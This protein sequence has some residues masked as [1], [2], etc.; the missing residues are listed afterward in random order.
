MMTKPQPS[1]PAPDSARKPVAAPAPAK[2]PRKK[3]QDRLPPL[4]WAATHGP[5]SGA[6]SATTGAAAVAL[7]G[8]AT[9]MPDAL[10]LLLGAAG[11]VGH[12][13][14]HSLFKHL[15][16]RT[17]VARCASWLLAGGWTTYAIT[18]G[19]LTWAC[20]GTLAGIGIGIGAMASNA[21][22]H[23]EVA[24]QDRLATTT[25]TAA[26]AAATESLDDKRR[27]VA[28]E[29]S[30]RIRRLT[31][32]DAPVTSVEFWKNG[33]G[34]S[35]GGHL[36]GGAIWT[37]IRDRARHMAADARLP[38]GCTIDVEEG[39]IQGTYVVDIT[40]VNIMS[41]IVDYPDDWTPLSILTGIPWGLRPSSDPVVV[42]LRE[43]C[44][45]ILGPPGSGKSTFL[46]GILAGFARCT[47][48][49]TWVIDLKGG[50]IG[51]PWAQPWLEAQGHAPAAHGVTQA[52]ADTQPGVDWIAHTP[53]EA[54]LML[55]AFLAIN[56]ARQ[57]G[58][59][60]LMNRANTTL[61]P[62]SAKIPQ[63]ELVIDEGAELLSAPNSDP[64]MKE[65]KRLVKKAMRTTRAMAERLVLTAIDGNLSAIGNTEVRKFSPVGV[66]LTSGENSTSNV[67]KLH[68]R[69][70]ID[71]NQLTEKGAG[72]IGQA[73]ADGFKPTAFKTWRTSPLMV[74]ACV[75]ATNRIRPT[76][77]QTSSTA[78]GLDY[79]N[80]WSAQRAGWLWG[81][82]DYRE[83]TIGEE[84]FGDDFTTP[85]ATA[86]TT[87]PVRRD[88]S[89]NLSYKRTP[90]PTPAHDDADEL[91][92]RLMREIDARYGTTEEPTT[93]SQGLNLSYKRNAEKID[94][95]RALIR[96][97]VGGAGPAGIDNEDL[98]QA[99]TTRFG[100]DGWDRTV[101]TT[102]ITKDCQSGLMHRPA[103][104]RVANGPEPLDEQA[105]E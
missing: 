94:P 28:E 50:A 61:L 23:E 29:W 103:R 96:D 57:H 5:V 39:N 21:A 32:L 24:E 74:R 63:I 78:A 77:D 55:R 58:Y 15:T 11:A 27:Q 100:P 44:A 66:A 19:P 41:D 12:G 4:D 68:P 10:P 56:A 49:L 101:V 9:G 54:L 95:R 20:A 98:Y 92:D 13:L 36:P 62:I 60:E 26:A 79:T 51:R 42:H 85:G 30:D 31:G 25:L 70:R 35:V 47:D 37:N 33:A 64:V 80:R 16:L 84:H 1:T 18:T 71:A 89:L 7:A 82:P 34:Y 73:G 104:G 38:H 105:P 97:L 8:A 88:G 59:Q 72:V 40:T 14:G 43:A 46:D 69:A 17:S 90:E 81:S 2:A 6:L 67:N 65:L 102:W 75:I 53:A 99:L 48:T 86:P 52:P 87:S 93:P 45:L 22:L 3:K 91:A 76:L 83:P